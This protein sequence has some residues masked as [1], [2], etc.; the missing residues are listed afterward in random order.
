MKPDADMSHR[1]DAAV[2]AEAGL[3]PVDDVVSGPSFPLTVKLLATALVL[4]LL[5]YGGLAAHGLPTPLWQQL[6]A[7][8]WAFLLGVLAVIASGYWGIMTSRT[9]IGPQY[10]DQTWL[11]HKRVNIAEITQVK[12]IRFHGLDWILV[13]RLVVRTGFGLATFHAAE[14]AVLAR[15]RLLAH[16]RP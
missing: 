1:A 15:F 2:A 11:W 6:D 9:S 16:G 14:P 5:V 13:P 7:G 3:A 12:L 4:G 8:D 10:L